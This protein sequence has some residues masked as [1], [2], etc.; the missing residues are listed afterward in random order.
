MNSIDDALMDAYIGEIRGERF[1]RRLLETLDLT[2]DQACALRAFADLERTTGARVGAHIAE[3][4]HAVPDPVPDR[5]DAAPDE[6]P[7]ARWNDLLDYLDRYAPLAIDDFRPIAA[8]AAA[9]A[10]G[11]AL[12]DHE[13]AYIGFV[14]AERAGDTAGAL[15]LIRAS[16]ARIGG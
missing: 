9:R 11:E 4:G 8:D 5:T 14:A 1:F 15:A 2:D 6:Y 7:I 16:D 12:I 10:I 13:I 3:R